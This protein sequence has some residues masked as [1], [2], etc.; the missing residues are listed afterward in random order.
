MC[1]KLPANLSI[2]FSDSFFYHGRLEAAERK[3]KESSS[4]LCQCSTT[5]HN[6]NLLIL[7]E[8]N[9]ATLVAR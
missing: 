4:F 5:L 6:I 3:G 7:P 9:K 8:C 1:L 2:D